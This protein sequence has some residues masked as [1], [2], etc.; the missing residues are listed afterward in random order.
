M[1][2]CLPIP[3]AAPVMRTVEGRGRG[4]DIKWI[5]KEWKRWGRNQSMRKNPRRKMR[6]G[7]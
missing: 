1:A 4:E 2:N 6:V 7:Q 5:Q 3:E